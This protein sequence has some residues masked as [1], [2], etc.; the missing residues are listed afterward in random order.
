MSPADDKKSS[1]PR[2]IM[3]VLSGHPVVY[4]SILSLAAAAVAFFLS[5]V[6]AVR[7]LQ[8]GGASSLGDLD[9]K[10]ASAQKTLDS[11]NR[12]IDAVAGLSLADRSRIEYA[13]PA[14]ADSPGALAQ[15]SA[16]VGAAG[17]AIA[18]AD[19]T[20]PNASTAQTADKLPNGV[21]AMD[22]SLNVAKLDYETFKIL[23]S[24]IQNNLRLID[25]KNFVFS[26]GGSV[27]MNLR[28]Y[29]RK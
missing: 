18:S 14:E 26:A 10:I 3:R 16:I 11:E 6:P 21:A 5:A 20:L 24:S 28:T 25:T 29:F 17:G 19:F 13:L 22:I 8:A 2:G 27:A 12:L 9:A 23:L 4:G 15:I 1:Q 7:S